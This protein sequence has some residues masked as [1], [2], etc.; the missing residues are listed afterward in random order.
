MRGQPRPPPEG[1]SSPLPSALAPMVEQNS[2]STSPTPIDCC[3]NRGEG[4]ENAN[5]SDQWYVN[6]YLIG[7]LPDHSS[8]SGQLQD[9][10]IPIPTI[11]RPPTPMPPSLPLP[12]AV[13]KSD[14]PVPACVAGVKRKFV[15]AKSTP[16]ISINP[17]RKVAEI[18][19]VL[20]LNMILIRH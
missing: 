18:P 1:P 7:T 6:Y 20:H 12:A 14:P 17:R 11:A 10:S 4:S 2:T 15:D 8:S 3:E 19:C 16:R 9:T 5:S 13:F